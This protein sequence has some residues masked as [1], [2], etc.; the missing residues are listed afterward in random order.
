MSEGTDRQMELIFSFY[1]GLHRKAPGSEAT[2]RRA[3][4]LLSNLPP[5]PQIVE[6]GCG[7]GAAALVLAESGPARVTAVDIHQ[8]FL[9]ELTARASRAGMADR[10]TAVQADMGDPPF[11]SD[12]FD[13]IWSEGAVYLVGFEEGLKRWRPLLRPGGYIAV[14][15]VAWLTARPPQKAVVFWTAEYP[16]ITH[17]EGNLAGIRA[18]W[19]VPLDH[20]V[21]PPEDWSNYFEPLKDHLRLFQ[22]QHAGD[23][24][25]RAFAD[26]LQHEIDMWNECGG[27]YGYVFFLAKRP[28]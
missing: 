19:F 13:V 15:E 27:S 7:S 17:V 16:A 5:D 1:E 26:S 20:F 22:T 14:S 18:A 9:D 4:S 12:S 8:P 11:P 3:L 2:T 10:V 28:E 25:V 21:M 6:F 23:Q 24:D